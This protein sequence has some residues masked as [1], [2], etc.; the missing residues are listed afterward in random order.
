MKLKKTLIR[1]KIIEFIAKQ[2]KPF[3]YNELVNFLKKS[4]HKFNNSTIFRNINLMIK[5]K[6]IKEIRIAGTKRYFES[7]NLPH[8]HHLICLNC[9]MIK[10]FY[11]KKIDTLIG[12]KIKNFFK[13]LKFETVD[14]SL[15]IFGYCQKCR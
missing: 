14:H 5:N 13:N 11:D 7:V 3:S 15:E 4:G 9:M 6:I 1:K 10:D 12:S 2:K 8:H